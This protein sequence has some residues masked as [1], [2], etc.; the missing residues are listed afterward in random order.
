MSI[1]YRGLL[2]NLINLNIKYFSCCREVT[3]I[4]GG[5]GGLWDHL[6]YCWDIRAQGAYAKG[7]HI[8]LSHVQE[9]LQI[10]RHL[11]CRLVGTRKHGH[12]KEEVAIASWLKCNLLERIMSLCTKQINS[13]MR[14]FKDE[15]DELK[16][17]A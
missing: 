9:G 6:H 13:T 11:L 1:D 3:I 14:S 12:C 4:K 5:G 2:L 8:S 10:N 15:H 7:S 17:I 16:T